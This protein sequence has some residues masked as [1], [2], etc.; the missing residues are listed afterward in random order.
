MFGDAQLA[1][2]SESII[3]KLRTNPAVVRAKTIL[4]Y[5][6]LYDEVD[7]HTF[8]DHLAQQGKEVLLPVVVSNTEMELRR[9][10]GTHD[11]RN[12]FFDI[13]EPVGDLFTDYD[14]IDVAVVP[15]MAFDSLGNRLGR[16]KGYYDRLLPQLTNTYKIGV[17]FPFQRVPAVP[18]DKHDVRMD[19]II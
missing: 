6:S 12:G 10:T 19:E 17:C 9:Y 8:I 14:K 4:M 15:G 7:T 1:E 5:Y 2:F 16:G 3:R 18:A 11:L 13:M